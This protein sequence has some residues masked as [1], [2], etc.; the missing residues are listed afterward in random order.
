M[1]KLG[2]NIDHVATLRQSRLGT[3]PDPV[4]AAMIVENCGAA[5]ITLHIREDRRHAQV[6]DLKLFKEVINIKVNLEMAATDDLKNVALTYKPQSCTIVPEKREELTTE[7]G[8]DL[9]PESVSYLKEYIKELKGEGIEVSLFID[10]IKEQIEKAKELG[11][12]AVEF[13]TGAY[14]DAENETIQDIEAERVKNGVAIAMNE[15][16]TP[17]VGHGLNY[18]NI[19]K[20]AAIKDIVEFNI[21]HSII[22]K[23]IFIGLD[24]AVKE[25]LELIS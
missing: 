10:P 6:R 4:Y 24:N 5:N 13:N 7:G 12:D 14:S 25:M 9:L 8:L 2:I 15:G 11:A 21:G 17:H 3:F 23:S 20:I 16:L 22:S 1:H 19:H 18:Q